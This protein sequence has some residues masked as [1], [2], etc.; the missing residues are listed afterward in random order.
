MEEGAI[1]KDH[2][3]EA[4][5]ALGERQRAITQSQ[6]ELQQALGEATRLQ[7]GLIQKQ[8]EGRTAQLEAQERIQQLEVEITQLKAKIAETNNLLKSAEA[9]MYPY[10]A[11]LV[12]SASL[13]NQEAGFVKTGMP[14]QVKFDAYPYQ[15]F[16]IV[17]GKV[18]SISPDAKSDER[19]GEVYRVEVAL[20]RNYITTNRQTIKFKAGQTAGAEIIIRRRRVADILLEPFRQLQKGGIDL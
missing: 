11:P 19:L 9:E 4:E 2:L 8:A 13:P 12:L 3:F 6:G 14:V 7:A 5:Q 17:P 16:G 18:I 1:A 15:D 20:A 10:N